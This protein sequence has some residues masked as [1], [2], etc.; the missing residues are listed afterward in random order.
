MKRNLQEPCILQLLQLWQTDAKRCLIIRSL[1]WIIHIVETEVKLWSILH[2]T[3]WYWYG[4]RTQQILFTIDCIWNIAIHLS[5][6]RLHIDCM[7]FT[8]SKL[9]TADGDI[10]AC[11]FAQL[12]CLIFTIKIPEELN[13]I[14]CYLTTIMR[15][16][17]CQLSLDFNLII[18]S[19]IARNL[20]IRY[21]IAL[22][23][24]NDWMLAN[25]FE[26]VTIY[27]ADFSRCAPISIS[28]GR[29]FCR[30]RYIILLTRSQRKVL[31]ADNNIGFTFA[32]LLDHRSTIYSI[33][34]ASFL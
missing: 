10:I 9:I 31:I 28:L 22:G 26:P 25:H 23:I 4:T 3:Q 20:I 32:I 1:E 16:S 21:D 24:S 18:V 17:C 8:Q 14:Q 29:I 5:S 13:I 19:L 2:Y 33:L 6:L 12:I 11:C 34:V 27:R 7:S 15:V 30:Y